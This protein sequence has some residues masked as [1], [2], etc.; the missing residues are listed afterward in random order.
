M[1]GGTLIVTKKT[2][3][4][5]DFV[6]EYTVLGFP[7]VEVTSLDK[8][9]LYFK[10]DELK[11]SLI[12]MDAMFHLAATPYMVRILLKHKRF[13]FKNLNIA[14]FAVD[15][16]PADLGMMFIANGVKSYLDI[17]DGKKQFEEGQIK[18]RDGKSYISPSVLKRRDLRDI[19]PAPVR[20]LTERHR[21][22]LMLACC[23]FDREE[24]A[25]CLEIEARTVDSHRGVIYQSL[26]TDNPTDLLKL[27][28]EIGLFTLKEL[29]FF[30]KKFEVKPKI[31]RGK[32]TKRSKKI[33][34][35]A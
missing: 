10:I 4:H 18:V 22:V 32:N 17:N 12:L 25:D 21:V 13:N 24:T 23:G 19:L 30:E 2:S 26:N 31:S 29:V 34:K 20:I 9:A 6:R 35:A 11:P 16:Y 8:D 3:R 5:Q 28:L 27:S 33:K 15:E 14:V 7:H 1:T